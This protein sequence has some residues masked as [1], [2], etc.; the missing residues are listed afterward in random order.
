MLA[1]L[2]GQDVQV[3]CT[4]PV[5]KYTQIRCYTGFKNVHELQV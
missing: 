1:F 3:K 2:Q 4:V 5:L